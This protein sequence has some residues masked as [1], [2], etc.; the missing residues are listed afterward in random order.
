MYSQPSIHAPEQPL[1]NEECAQ[2]S[3]SI[4][5]RIAPVVAGEAAARAALRAEARRRV[6]RGDNLGANRDAGR[7][8]EG[9][10]AT[11]AADTPAYGALLY[12]WRFDL[13]EFASQAPAVHAARRASVRRC[14]E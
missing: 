2:S 4:R 8:V 11:V 10:V 3:H 5:G 1:L 12:S 14:D 9:E 13:R 7:G 6:A